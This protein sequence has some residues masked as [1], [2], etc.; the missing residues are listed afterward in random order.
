MATG[1]ARLAFHGLIRLTGVVASPAERSAL[2]TMAHSLA[3]CTGVED[4]HL[5]G[6]GI[7]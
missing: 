5:P 7:V 3:G 2:L 6:P 1:Y 4:R